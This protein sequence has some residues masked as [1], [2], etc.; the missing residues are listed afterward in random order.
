[1]LIKSAMLTFV[2]VVLVLSSLTPF[3]VPF[4]VIRLI[5]SSLFKPL[6]LFSV[7]FM[8]VFDKSVSSV[9]VSFRA[10]SFRFV[11]GRLKFKFWA[12]ILFA[13]IEFKLSGV[14]WL[15]KFIVFAN[16]SPSILAFALLKLILF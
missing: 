8:F 11:L 15:P 4:V 5:L 6:A 3:R 14:V 1:M 9:V 7:T 13:T 2:K 12:K 10:V 16:I